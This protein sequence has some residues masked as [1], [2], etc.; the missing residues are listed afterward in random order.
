MA[1]TYVSEKEFE[2]VYRRHLHAVFGFALRCVCRREIAEE[3]T[4]EAFLALYQN[5]P[6]IDKAQL[7]SWLFTVVKNRSLDYWRRRAVELRHAES[8]PDCITATDTPLSVLLEIK[9]LKPIH[10]ICLLL[11]Y[12]HGMD[13]EEI[14]KQ[15]GLT[16]DQ[17]KSC[18]QYGRRLLREQMLL[19][20]PPH[21]ANP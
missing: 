6:R 21:G 4:S 3:I 7:P 15:T 16:P 1:S 8:Q 9:A 13:R 2:E 19:D 17:V 12:A 11:R 10:R 14:G 20:N 18:L 5:F